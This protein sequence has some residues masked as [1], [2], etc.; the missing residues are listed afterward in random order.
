MIFGTDIETIDEKSIRVIENMLD[1]TI[2]QFKKIME[3]QFI[4]LELIPRLNLRGPGRC[5]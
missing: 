5:L 2:Q 4:E 3:Y 1:Q